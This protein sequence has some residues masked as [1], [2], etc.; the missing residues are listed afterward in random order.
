M[1]MFANFVGKYFK[2]STPLSENF[3]IFSRNK[4]KFSHEIDFTGCWKLS[5]VMCFE[6]VRLHFIRLFSVGLWKLSWDDEST[7]S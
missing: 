6:K 3:L 4:M 2:K 7:S 1:K 5:F